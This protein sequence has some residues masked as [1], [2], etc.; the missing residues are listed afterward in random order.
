MNGTMHL[1]EYMHASI[2]DKTTHHP[3]EKSLV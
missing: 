2:R 1:T 3:N